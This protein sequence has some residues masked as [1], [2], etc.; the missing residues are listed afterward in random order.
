MQQRAP[1]HFKNGFGTSLSGLTP[2]S[3]LFLQPNYLIGGMI[4]QILLTSNLAEHLSILTR[5]T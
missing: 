3:F 4:A 1:G 2:E 5:R